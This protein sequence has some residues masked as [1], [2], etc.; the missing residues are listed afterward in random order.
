MFTSTMK[1]IDRDGCQDDYFGIQITFSGSAPNICIGIAITQSGGDK[2]PPC[3][4]DVSEQRT[5]WERMRK[6]LAIKKA[7]YDVRILQV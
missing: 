6:E 4:S 7:L 3:R 5:L 1:D 2:K